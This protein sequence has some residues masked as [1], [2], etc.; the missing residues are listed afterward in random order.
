MK[1]LLLAFILVLVA[2]G[3]SSKSTP[4]DAGPIDAG[5]E[6]ACGHP[7]DMGNAL[8]VGIYCP[9]GTECTGSGT[10]CSSIVNN[11]ATP[12]SNTYVCILP[13]CDTC[14]PAACG[15]DAYCVCSASLGGCG[16][17]P[18]SCSSFAA[19]I[20]GT[21]ACVDAGTLVDAGTPEDAG[22]AD[23]G[24]QDAGAADAG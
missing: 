8:G 13:N 21:T 16:C 5:L 18:T 1:R 2:C 17:F 11:P 3:S 10:L 9:T 12:A 6:S 14:D 4:A 23:A 22:T 19:S 20:G 7:G 15:Q 24:S